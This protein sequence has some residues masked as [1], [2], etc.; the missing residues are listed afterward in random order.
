[1][2]QAIEVAAGRLFAGIGLRSIAE[3]PP[4]DL[5]T[6]RA[7]QEG[8]TIWVAIVD[9]VPVGYALASVVDGEGHLDQVSVLPELGRRGIGTALVERVEAWARGAG[10]RA[11]TLTTFRDVEWNGPYYTKLGFA[12]LDEAELGPELAAIRERERANGLDVGPR[13]AMRKPL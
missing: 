2:C 5:E 13:Q 6:L 11:L 9:D 8:G 7:H 12:A 10:R 3:A 1:V 4:D